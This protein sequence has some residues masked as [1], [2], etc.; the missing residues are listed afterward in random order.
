MEDKYGV[1]A[2]GY[3]WWM[4]QPGGSRLTSQKWKP[5]QRHRNSSG[6]KATIN[7]NPH[8]NRPFPMSAIR[9]PHS[10]NDLREGV[11]GNCEGKACDK[12]QLS[13]K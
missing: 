4:P 3:D 10:K 2:L 11:E 5:R 6:E 13:S 8:P 9:Q 1:R 12:A 7:P